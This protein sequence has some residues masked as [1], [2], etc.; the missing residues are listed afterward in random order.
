MMHE[1]LTTIYA[2][3]LSERHAMRFDFARMLDSAA[4]IIPTG[5]VIRGMSGRLMAIYLSHP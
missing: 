1:T 2:L 5:A 4:M 3:T